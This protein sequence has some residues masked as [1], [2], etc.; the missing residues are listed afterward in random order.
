LSE[1]ETRAATFREVFSVGE[2]RAVFVS[3]VLSWVGDYMVKAAITALVYHTTHSAAITAISFAISYLPWAVGGPLL[4]ALAERYPHRTTM[5]LCDLIRGGL[6]LLIALLPLPTPVIL[7]LLFCTALFTPPFE[8]ARSATLPRILPGDGYVLALSVQSATI[9]GAQVTGYLAGSA[10]SI[11]SPR[12]ALLIDAATFAASAA[13]IRLGVRWR[14]AVAQPS[15]RTHLVREAAEGF[16]VVFRT[17][18]LRAI[19]VLILAS[20][21]F[22]A[23][24]EGLAAVW[25]GRLEADDPARRGLAQAIIMVGNPIGFLIAGLLFARLVPP[26]LRVRLMRPLAVAIPLCTVPALLN[27]S[28][29]VVALL[30]GL[31]GAAGAGLLPAANGQFVQAL[32]MR[33]RARAFGVM[34]TGMQLLQGGSVLVTGVLAS[35]FPLPSVVGW[36][37]VGGVVMLLLV[38]ARWPAQAVFDQTIEDTKLA[39]AA[40]EAAPAPPRPRATGEE[41]SDG[42]IRI[43]EQT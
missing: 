1:A 34:S 9:M 11:S 33:Y 17:P 25:A 22:A 20:V 42:R 16:S 12:L 37:S 26:R 28:A 15:Q 3:T 40:A 6:M 2:F 13:A 7:L 23:P 5:V 31:A 18:A 27:P 29:P 32:P 35:Y 10:L 19:A 21:L 30:A 43:V 4:T 8:A 14:P 38:V 36:W 39:N 41:P 24:P